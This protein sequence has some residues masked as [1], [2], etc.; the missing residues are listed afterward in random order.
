MRWVITIF[1]ALGGLFFAYLFVFNERDI[2]A[3]KWF[4]GVAFEGYLF[5]L[6]LTPNAFE[7][8]V[9]S[10]TFLKSLAG[11]LVGGICGFFVYAS[12]L[13]RKFIVLIKH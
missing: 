1:F 2:G 7:N 6:L 9:S 12:D 3:W 11:L 10:S 5:K 8:I 4:W 13:K